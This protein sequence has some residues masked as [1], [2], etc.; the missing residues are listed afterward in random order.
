MHSFVHGDGAVFE[1]MIMD[2][3]S[4]A[5]NWLANGLGQQVCEHV[6]VLARIVGVFVLYPMS[7]VRCQA[8][9]K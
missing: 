5:L 4:V 7:L 6:F 1:W 3:L 2:W 8:Q 9:G